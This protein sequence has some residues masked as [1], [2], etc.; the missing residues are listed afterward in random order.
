MTRVPFLLRA[1]PVLLVSLLLGCAGS[2]GGGPRAPSGEPLVV[3]AGGSSFLRFGASSVELVDVESDGAPAGETDVVPAG[4]GKP[5]AAGVDRETG[6]AA[7]AY[8]RK[9]AVV[10]LSRGTVRWY[11]PAWSKS[12]VSLAVTAGLAAAVTGDTVAIYTLR[13]GQCVQREDL[14]SWL[15]WFD[16]ERLVYAL[17]LSRTRFLLV[18]FKPMGLTSRSQAMVQEIDLGGM[19]RE[20]TAVGVLPGLTDVQACAYVG[21]ALYVAG[22]LEEDRRLPGRAPQPGD[23]KQTLIV[24]R[25]EPAGLKQKAVVNL[26]RHEFST[27]VR[28]LAVGERALSVIL[29]DGEL[30][31]FEL[32]QGAVASQPVE[33]TRVRPGTSAT[34]LEGNRL[35]LIG[36]GGT[37]VVTTRVSDG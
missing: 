19:T 36:P 10:E 29:E 26:E 2:S 13:D 37:E 25:V 33:R 14:A 1:G 8:E 3:P 18:G 28:E 6:W 9:L 32:G 34:W 23:L 35:A 16:L 27:R 21:N 7:V 4:A 31:V 15:E 5:A 11:D 22:V 17:P 24:Y 20:A 30:L 12:P